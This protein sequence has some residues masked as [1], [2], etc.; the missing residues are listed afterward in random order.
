MTLQEF[1]GH[2]VLAKAG[3]GFLDYRGKIPSDFREGERVSIIRKSDLDILLKAVSMPYIAEL[4]PP[5][6]G[7]MPHVKEPLN[8]KEAKIP[9]RVMIT[10]DDGSEQA[11]IIDGYMYHMV[12]N[13]WIRYRPVKA[14]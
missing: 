14:L 7:L 4:I 2:G 13:I 6:A 3:D 8:D 1:I 9:T 5:L 12:N 11:F 10:G